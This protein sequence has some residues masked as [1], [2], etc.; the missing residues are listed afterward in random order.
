MLPKEY[1]LAKKEDFSRVYEKGLY[2]YQGNLAIKYLRSD[3][4]TPRFG[5]S[6]GKNYSKLAVR[7]N[8][9]RRIL[10][11]AVQKLLPEM[12]IGVDIIVMIRPANKVG[13]SEAKMSVSEAEKNLQV[14]FLK[15][16]LY[17]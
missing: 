8:S 2:F 14:I 1:R 17:K 12:Q 11:D 6:I 5:F 15:T 3:L 10:R 9:A 7:R 4:Q 16:N 13:S